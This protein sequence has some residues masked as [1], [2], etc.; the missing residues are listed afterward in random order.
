VEDTH[1][2]GRGKGPT[3]VS[4]IGAASGVHDQSFYFI[5]HLKIDGI[6]HEKGNFLQR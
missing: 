2:I 4:R 5:D 3:G 1:K 6:R